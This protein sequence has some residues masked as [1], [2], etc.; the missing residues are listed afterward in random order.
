ME[1]VAVITHL[2]Y[3]A[4]EI[5]ASA[6]NDTWPSDERHPVTEAIIQTSFTIFEIKKLVGRLVV[7]QEAKKVISFLKEQKVDYTLVFFLQLPEKLKKT[8]EMIS[9]LS[10]ICLDMKIEIKNSYF[11]EAIWKIFENEGILPVTPDKFIVAPK[12]NI[13]IEEYEKVKKSWGCHNPYFFQTYTTKEGKFTE[14]LYHITRTAQDGLIRL[15]DIL[16]AGGF[17]YNGKI[18]NACGAFEHVLSPKTLTCQLFDCEIKSSAF[19]D[20]KTVE[21]IKE[22]VELFPRAMSYL[23][24][25][26]NLISIEDFITFIVKDR[27]R[28][29][30][31]SHKISNHFIAYICAT[32][33]MHRQAMEICL[34]DEWKDNID[35]A[36]QAI[37]ETG[38][39]PER[40]Y[41][42]KGIF[43]SL[44]TLD[45]S[46]IKSNGITT[47]FS[48]KEHDHPFPNY[49]HTD[50]VI[51]A[52]FTER[53][54][55]L[56]RPQDLQG[57]NIDNAQR[58][59]LLYIQS[60]TLPHH[61]MTYYTDEAMETLMGTSAEESAKVIIFIYFFCPHWDS[62][63]ITPE[64]TT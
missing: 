49:T 63:P 34:N 27:T 38:L 35:T 43:A 39:L 16:K 36:S 1:P 22:M 64:N 37:K 54:E 53:Y 30:G 10:H 20:T 56:K 18:Y 62:N 52:E 25:N 31:K 32:K 17:M 59:M 21:E 51:G 60:Y 11:F 28:Q 55:C 48:R 13:A 8:S 29:T 46:A 44:L 47:A 23:M 14:H 5:L 15:L 33:E 50:E 26:Y 7:K 4:V 57:S 45:Y 42:D 12:K 6:K 41:A 19:G 3:Q 61:N 40:C 9:Y 58:L 24:I 2:L